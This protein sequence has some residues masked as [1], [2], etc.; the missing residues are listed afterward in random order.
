MNKKSVNQILF[1]EPYRF[2]FFQAVRVFERLF[3]EKGAVGRDALPHEEPVRFRSHISL[4]FPSSEIQEIREIKNETNDERRYDMLVNFMGIVGT[5]GVLPVH[6]T[7]LVLDRIRHHDTAM[8][9]FFD[10]FTHRVVSMHYRA[11][12]K[13]RFPVAYERGNDEFTSYL[14]DFAGLGTDKI[15]GRMGLDDESMLPYVGLIA[16]KPHSS[17]A[18]ENV[19]SDYFRVPA[20]I[21]QMFGLWLDLAESDYTRVGKARSTLGSTAIL[22]KRIWDQQSKF[23]VRLGPMAFAQFQA[24]LPNGTA[25]RPFRSIVNFMAGVEG[26]FDLQLLLKAKQIP[27]LVLTTRAMRRPMLGWT[28]WLKTKP[29]AADDEQVVLSLN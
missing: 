7:E 29:F 13:Y 12:G 21:D 24:F 28:T 17:S 15:R 11:W 3:P 25:N 27:G 9:S 8:W 22:G 16:Q 6:Y 18:V 19:L 10:I 23:R 4:N 14:F 20:K 1:D 2:E 26:E 5:S